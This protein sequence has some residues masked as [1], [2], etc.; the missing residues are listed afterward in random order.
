MLNKEILSDTWAYSWTSKFVTPVI[1]LSLYP[2]FSWPHKK[3]NRN[4]LINRE[5]LSF[6]LPFKAR[7]Y[8]SAYSAK[9]F[10]RSTADRQRKGSFETI[11]DPNEE[12]VQICPIFKSDWI[13]HLR[14]RQDGFVKSVN[15]K[16]IQ[17]QLFLSGSDSYLTNGVWLARSFGFKKP[18]T[19]KLYF[20]GLDNHFDMF[21]VRREDQGVICI[22]S[23]DSDVVSVS[24]DGVDSELVDDESDDDESTGNEGGNN[25]SDV[26]SDESGFENVSPL[27]WKLNVTSV[28]A[29]VKKM[30]VGRIPKKIASGMLRHRDMI[31]M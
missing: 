1:I 17:V 5:Q 13:H 20:E 16:Y 6:L 18:T 7:M 9:R 23:D 22:S 30:Q 28:V 29:S 11:I 2:L 4:I 31:L 3:R 19:V 10:T 21:V 24:S 27:S 26:D 14:K 12:K 25:D 15:N 8:S